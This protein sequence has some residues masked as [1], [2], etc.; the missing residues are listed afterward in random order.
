ME[1]RKVYDPEQI[2]TLQFENGSAIVL[3]APGC[4]KTELLGMRIFVAN[5]RYKIP[6]SEMLCLTFTNRAS[7]EMKDRVRSLARGGADKVLS[8]LFV[9]N[10]HRFCIR[11][12]FENHIIPS[13]T[14]IIDDT[15]QEEILDDLSS[16][17]LCRAWQ[18]NLTLKCSY[19]L[20][21]QSEEFPDEI[22][23]M[24]IVKEKDKSNFSP[25]AQ[26]YN[27]YKQEEQ[28]IDYEDILLLTYKALSEEDYQQKYKYS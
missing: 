24:Y 2:E 28:V 14:S 7:R 9:G 23:S 13:N 17:V 11:F 16:G 12:L 4:G 26:V 3:A 22:R 18:I 15:D 27:F 6:F 20:T 8:E 1:E 21:T 10:I 5:S 19:F 25:Y